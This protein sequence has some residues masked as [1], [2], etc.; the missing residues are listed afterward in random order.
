MERNKRQKYGNDTAPGANDQRDSP[1]I[2]N[3][4]QQLNRDLEETIRNASDDEQSRK[5]A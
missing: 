3:L 2:R 1:T 5:S 4:I